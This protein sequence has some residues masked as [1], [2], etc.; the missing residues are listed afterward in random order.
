MSERTSYK[1]NPAI[2]C[3]IKHITDSEY[4]ENKNIFHTIFG[5]VKRIRIIATIIEKKEELTEIDDYN[6]GL[7]DD[8][9]ENVQLIFNLDDGTSLI[10]AIVDNVDPENYKKF[11]VGHTVDVV[12]RPRKKEDNLSL[13][14]EIIR[15][16]EEPNYILLRDAEIIKRIKSGDIQKISND[17][18]DELSKEIDVNNLFEDE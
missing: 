18:T 12:G 7:E 4:E 10:R 2:H 17:E 15:K 14:I 3:W 1:R 8:N 13:W 5:L 11:S 9:K 16:V 6:F